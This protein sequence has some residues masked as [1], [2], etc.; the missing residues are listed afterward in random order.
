MDSLKS[1][2]GAINKNYSDWND[3][4]TNDLKVP[5]QPAIVCLD[6]NE[7]MNRPD[8]QLSILNRTKQIHHPAITVKSRRHGTGTLLCT[9]GPTNR[10]RAI[11]VLC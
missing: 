5:P 10:Y 4:I 11:D 8:A 3:S 7:S 9:E 6:K 1:Y 2:A